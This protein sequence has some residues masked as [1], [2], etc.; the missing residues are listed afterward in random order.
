MHEADPPD[1][2]RD[3]IPMAREQGK[4]I[5]LGLTP[6]RSG[7][8]R[9]VRWAC[10]QIPEDLHVHG[11]AMREYTRVRRLNSTD[12]T[13]WLLDAMAVNKEFPWLTFGEAVEIIVKRYVRWNR[14]IVDDKQQQMELSA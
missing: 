11:W 12:S 1:L 3:L 2:L 5:G 14:V 9:W 8:E 10:E 7:K 4:W 6:P 13:N